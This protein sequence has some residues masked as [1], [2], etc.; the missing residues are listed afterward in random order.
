MIMKWENHIEKSQINNT[1]VSHLDLY[2][3]ILDIIGTSP[4]K[5]DLDGINLWPMISLGKEIP[6]RPLIWHFPIYL[7]AYKPMEDDGRDILFRTRPGSVIRL[8][9]WKLHE[10][11]EDGG[12][13]FYNLVNDPGE[14]INLADSIPEK[15]DEL[16]QILSNWRSEHNAPIPVMKNPE[17]DVKSETAK[18]DEI[19]GKYK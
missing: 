10:Y 3:S 11:F 13:E 16:Y 8:G 12:I 9:K 6:L 1:P 7:Q 4:E 15:R 17:Y 19:L 18:M 14:R 5:E 2:P